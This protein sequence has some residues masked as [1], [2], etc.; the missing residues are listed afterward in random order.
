[1][2]VSAALLRSAAPAGVARPSDGWGETTLDDLADYFNGYAFKPED[3]QEQGLP[4]VRIAQ[5]TSPHAPCDRYP[6]RLPDKYRVDDGDLIFSWSA[7]LMTMI[8]DRGPA[9]LNQHLFKVVPKPGTD[10][11]FLHHLL[12][13]NMDALAG[14]AHGTTMKHI[15]RS[16]LLPFRILVPGE[17]H[18][19]AIACVLDTIDGAIRGTERVVTKLQLV[20]QAM[21]AEFFP[22]YL[23]E[24]GSQPAPKPKHSAG[25]WPTVTLED[26]ADPSAPICYGIV[27]AGAFVA[28][29]PNVLTIG[30]LAGDFRTG[31]HRTS[32]E[33]DALYARSRARPDDIL[34][35]IK[36]TI[37]RVAVVPTWYAGNISRDLGRLRLRNSMFPEF[38]KQYLLSPSGQSQLQRAVVGTTRAELS[39]FTLKRLVLPRPD[40]D[41]QVKIAEQL[42]ATD[43]A[44]E[45]ERAL[46]RKLGLLR[47]GLMDDL[48]TGRT[49]TTGIVEA[50]CAA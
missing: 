20:K 14:Q 11:R 27:Q 45:G 19:R 42:V 7:T 49:S 8:W 32:P 47:E 26:A 9:Y 18:Q 34:I 36:G 41:E 48:V 29:G 25:H 5:L 6:G 10:L 17:P 31:L 50:G 21:L 33:I 23:S 44:I 2:P 37:G 40:L 43:R 24:R 46:L 4:I 38:A 39:I 28:N 13:F 3:W 35:S 12:D 15:K 30:D 22:D 1:M 16:D